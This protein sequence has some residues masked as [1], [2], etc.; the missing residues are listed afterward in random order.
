GGFTR[1][2]EAV[3]Q[4]ATRH[5]ARIHTG[6]TVVRVATEDAAPAPAGR[7]GL[8]ARLR[9]R[10]ARARATGVVWRDAD[11]PAP[12][13]AADL[14]VGAGDLHHLETRLLPQHLRTYPQSYW[15]R[16]SSGPGAVLVLLGVR[17]ELPALPHHSLFFTSDWHANFDAIFAGR[18]PSPA[19]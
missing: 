12:L 14:V 4:Q 5:G 10:G 16:R 17:G 2:I 13:H 9:G 18:V 15:D 6:A 8:R 1:L 3:A 11:G 19:S 7:R